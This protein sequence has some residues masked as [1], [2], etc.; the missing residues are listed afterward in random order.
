MQMSQAGLPISNEID[1]P[2][3][4]YHYT[5]NLS[6]Q[7]AAMMGV[8]R[9]LN[10]KQQL[11]Q[12]LRL[13]LEEVSRVLDAES[14][15][16]Y[17]LNS[18]KN[19]LR[20]HMVENGKIVQIT[21][22]R[23]GGIADYV[24][25]SGKIVNVS[26][27]M[28]SRSSYYS[29]IARIGEEPVHS[30]LIVPII[31][32]SGSICGC[33]QVLNK[34]E[35]MFDRKDT[36]YLMTMADLIAMAIQNTLLQNEARSGRELE[37]EIS[38]AVSI[39]RQLLPEQLPQIGG[40]DIHA[41]NKPSKYVGGDYYDFFPFPRTL[42][43]TLADVSGKGVPAA[44][45]TANAHAFLHACVNEIDGCRTIVEK[46]NNHFCLYTSGDMFA[47]FFWATL[48]HNT[49]RLK[50]VNAGHIPPIIVKQ[51]GTLGK[52]NSHG[53]PI[54]IMDSFDYRESEIKLDKGD[55]L[56]LFSDGLTEAMNEYNEQFGKDRLRNI[57]RD[58]FF[59]SAESLS[60]KVLREIKR[61]SASDILTDD[62]TLIVVKRDL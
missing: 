31:N 23:N 16:F 46:L 7:L 37:E 9:L 53:L 61:F 10:S 54:G 5:K 22:K 25:N 41:F 57:V 28:Q 15:V 47:T 50:Y 59:L 8:T 48:N 44:L 39:Q 51:D 14:A 56:V 18:R 11:D 55:T 40:Y 6:R 30:F 36:Q 26:D 60:K 62:M 58:N 3:T 2:T 49:H 29:E 12:Q 52:L 17:L 38:R 19:E 20:A 42:S 33:L 4:R 1:V 43:F 45:L 13:M 35:G 24:I 32:R 27:A 21:R 34:R